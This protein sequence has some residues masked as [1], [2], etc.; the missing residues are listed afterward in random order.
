[1][2]KTGMSLFIVAAAVMSSDVPMDLGVSS[3]VLLV[4]AAC[5]NC[6]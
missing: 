4:T 5:S 1:M 3:L 6:I 2:L